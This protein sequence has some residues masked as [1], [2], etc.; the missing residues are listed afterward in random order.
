MCARSCKCTHAPAVTSKLPQLSRIASPH[1]HHVT[2]QQ[3]LASQTGHSII[4]CMTRVSALRVAFTAHIVLARREATIGRPFINLPYA[5]MCTDERAHE[6]THGR[7][8]TWTAH[9][10]IKTSTCVQVHTCTRA[11]VW[12]CTPNAHMHAHR[13]PWRRTLACKA[14]MLCLASCRAARRNELFVQ[15]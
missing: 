9:V 12:T 6:R 14:T 7:T 2:N 8:D 11:E 5:R 4:M 15:R 3:M 13:S 10:P 1:A